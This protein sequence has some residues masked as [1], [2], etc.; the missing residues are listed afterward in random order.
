VPLAAASGGGLSLVF[1]DPARVLAAPLEQ[2]PVPGSRRRT[3]VALARAALEDEALFQRGESL[4]Q[5]VARLR[6]IPG[7]GEWTAQYIALRAAGEPDAFPASDR[8]LLRGATRPGGVEPRA[9]ELLQRA[10]PWR[11]WRAYAA[12]HL[13][14]VDAGRRASPQLQN[15]FEGSSRARAGSRG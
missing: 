7:V 6:A 15:V 12:Q 8:G 14:A 2:L 3:L 10:E 11:P 1:P 9:A 4:E 5:T 13:W